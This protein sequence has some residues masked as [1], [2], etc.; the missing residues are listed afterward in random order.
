[1]ARELNL[2]A[3]ILNQATLETTPSMNN[4]ED[5]KQRLDCPLFEIDYGTTSGAIHR[6]LAQLVESLID[7]Y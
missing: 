3:V 2:V 1:M 6:Q 4:A 7:G 5:L